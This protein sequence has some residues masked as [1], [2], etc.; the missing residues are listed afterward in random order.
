MYEV[1][2]LVL[3]T[4]LTRGARRKAAAHQVS[5]ASPPKLD[6]KNSDRSSLAGGFYPS[7]T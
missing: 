2:V 1:E 4:W 7:K 5:F 3:R 6:A